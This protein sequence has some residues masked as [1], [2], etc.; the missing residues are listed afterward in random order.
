VQAHRF[1]IHALA[2]SL[3]GERVAT[4]DT[5]GKIKLW[6]A[7][8]A[9]ARLVLTG[10]EG[11]IRGLAF[12]REASVLLSAADDGR[13]RAW[14]LATGRCISD[15]E[16]HRPPIHA[17]GAR[18]DGGRIATGGEDGRA[19]IWDADEIRC[20]QTIPLSNRPIEAVAL[21]ATLLAAV[22]TSGRLMVHTLGRAGTPS[23]S[24]DHISPIR[25]PASASIAFPG[26]GRLAVGGPDRSLRIW[27]L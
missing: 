23:L 11:G 13:F 20:V 21:S 7:Y 3:D 9:R 19:R 10:S 22:D 15:I 26:G 2:A 14:S 6:D 24:R 4:G 8:P 16:A 27:P 12:N 1:P 25:G 5:D 17:W 18:P